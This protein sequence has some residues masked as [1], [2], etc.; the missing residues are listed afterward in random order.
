M[1]DIDQVLTRFAQAGKSSTLLV[2]QRSRKREATVARELRNDCGERTL[3]FSFA[4]TF[5]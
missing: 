5:H 4:A 2:R 3:P 1:K